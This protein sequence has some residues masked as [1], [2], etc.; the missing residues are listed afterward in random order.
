M[1]PHCKNRKA[2]L[3]AWKQLYS[4]ATVNLH[5]SLYGARHGKIEEVFQIEH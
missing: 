5:T 2:P 4:D 1:R 3:L